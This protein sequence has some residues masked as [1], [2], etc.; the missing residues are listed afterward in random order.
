MRKLPFDKAA[1]I[2]SLIDKMHSNESTYLLEL[3]QVDKIDTL[4][5]NGPLG[6]LIWFCLETVV[7]D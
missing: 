5:S 3:D 4:L 1:T 6:Q 7:W 2:C